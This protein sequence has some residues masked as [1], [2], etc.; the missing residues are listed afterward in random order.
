MSAI[1]QVIHRVGQCF[2]FPADIREAGFE[3]LAKSIEQFDFEP[4]SNGIASRG[5]KVSS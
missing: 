5:L 2:A 4:L 1:G 3:L